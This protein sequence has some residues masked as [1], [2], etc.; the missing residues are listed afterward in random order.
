MSGAGIQ[1]S[2][3][4]IRHH[5]KKSQSIHSDD[6]GILIFTSRIP[7]FLP[8]DYTNL[9]TADSSMFTCQPFSKKY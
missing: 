8:Y 4:N 3:L 7:V 9:T 2:M 5:Q 6:L 1:V